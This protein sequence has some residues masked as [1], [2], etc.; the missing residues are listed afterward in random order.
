M[1][2]RAETHTSETVNVKT[3]K[4]NDAATSNQDPES[5]AEPFRNLSVIQINPAIPR[6]TYWQRFSLTSTSAGSFQS[7]ARHA[8]QPFM[9]LFTIPAVG[10]M[11]LV[12]GVMLAWS[13][14]MTVT[15][16]SYMLGPPWN[17]TA[18][19]IGLMSLPPFIGSTIGSLI[20]GSLSDWLILYLSRKNNGIFE[21]EMRLWVVLPF[22]FCLPIGSFIYGY[23]LNN[24][25]S[26]PVIA[27]ANGVSNFGGAPIS[28]IALTYITDS[29]TEVGGRA[30]CPCLISSY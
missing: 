7:F 3:E 9:I 12:Y 8:Y 4:P 23:G 10:Y 24:G 28:A 11:S 20:C 22:I 2:K 25:W 17:F 5:G 16:S 1:L 15:L 14:V 6:K 30:Y 19:Q 26:W 27:V 13:T 18:A 21:P 29:Y